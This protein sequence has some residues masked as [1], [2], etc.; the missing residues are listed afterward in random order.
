V[1]RLTY[2]GNIDGNPVVDDDH[3]E[4]KWFTLAEIK[5]MDVSVLDNYF[6]ELVNEGVISL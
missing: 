3:T 4:A 6:K 5:N 2:I 1:V